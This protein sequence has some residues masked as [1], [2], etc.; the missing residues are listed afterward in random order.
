MNRI[1]IALLTSIIC[2]VVAADFTYPSRRYYSGTTGWE[3][4][5]Y[6]WDDDLVNHLKAVADRS[7]PADSHPTLIFEQTWRSSLG[8]RAECSVSTF[9]GKRVATATGKTPREA[10]HAA[11]DQWFRGYN[12]WMDQFHPLPK[13]KV[14]K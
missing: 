3:K 9:D 2:G 4:I 12:D 5:P 10:M 8:G 6:Q 7:G 13:F 1:T 14:D 11:V